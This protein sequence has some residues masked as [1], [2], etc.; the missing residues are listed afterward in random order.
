M[1]WESSSVDLSMQ[2]YKSLRLSVMICVTLVNTQTDT[3]TDCFLPAVLLAQPA[4]I[5]SVIQKSQYL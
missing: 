5:E 4:E 2:N 3:Q 1:S